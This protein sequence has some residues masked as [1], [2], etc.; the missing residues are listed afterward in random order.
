MRTRQSLFRCFICLSMLVAPTGIA[1]SL[2]RCLPEK[3][4]GG[5]FEINVKSH[6]QKTITVNELMLD[7]DMDRRLK[8]LGKRE[9]PERHLY[10]IERE[11]EGNL[12]GYLGFKESEWVEKINFK[13]P[14]KPATEM[15]MYREHAEL[16]AEITTRIFQFKQVLENHDKYGLRLIN[17]CGESRFESLKALDA[18][19][20]EQLKVYDSLEKLRQDLLGALSTFAEA[21][22][23]RDLSADYQECLKGSLRQLNDLSEKHYELQN[24][25]D[26][27]NK[28]PAG[29]EALSPARGNTGSQLE[30]TPQKY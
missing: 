19:I 3:S 28:E 15:P 5:Q 23:C 22:T 9:D 17:M 21:G 6:P 10:R 13:G 2:D 29:T 1:W 25:V 7:R 26:R 11:G 8:E 24:K 14:S 30:K 20:R 16:L 27:M 18:N 12:V 4:L